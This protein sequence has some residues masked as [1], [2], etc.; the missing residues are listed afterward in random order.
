[1]T[2]ST[3]IFMQLIRNGRQ[4]EIWALAT[5]R[6]EMEYLQEETN[7]LCA[8]DQECDN[9][10]NSSF[11]E[12]RH[13]VQETMW[14]AQRKR[15]GSPAP[16]KLYTVLGQ[17]SDRSLAKVQM[18]VITIKLKTRS[19]W[20]LTPSNFEKVVRWD[21]KDNQPNYPNF[22]PFSFWGVLFVPQSLF[23]ASLYKIR[24]IIE[25]PAGLPTG[26]KI[27]TRISKDPWLQV[28][29]IRGSCYLQ[30]F[31]W[32]YLQVTFV[33]LHPCPALSQCGYMSLGSKMAVCEGVN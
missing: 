32:V 17:Q 4:E 28:N 25:V 24:K 14:W 29:W 19:F 27:H 8:V 12:K 6:G 5:R 13:G 21:F 3:Q 26:R 2:F 20:L 22:P 18:F 11:W 10:Q 33:D 15:T 7:N 31:P 23:G 30:V 1:M 16:S 9:P